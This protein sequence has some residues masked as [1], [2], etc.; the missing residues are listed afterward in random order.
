MMTFARCY[1]VGART[2]AENELACTTQASRRSAPSRVFCRPAIIFPL[3]L[4][5]A[6]LLPGCLLFQQQVVPE[7]TSETDRRAQAE[8]QSR[9]YAQSLARR[10]SEDYRSQAM[11]LLPVLA[12]RELDTVTALVVEWY[13][14]MGEVFPTSATEWAEG[15]PRLHDVRQRAR[16]QQASLLRGDVWE[17]GLPAQVAASTAALMDTLTQYELDREALGN[18]PPERWLELRD[19]YHGWIEVLRILAQAAAAD[20]S[21]AWLGEPLDNGVQATGNGISNSDAGRGV[22]PDEL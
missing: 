4:T 14:I 12:T 3:F 2:L 9:E 13:D 8:A 11:A 15:M 10:L 1:H 5:M 19:A 6:L 22:L 21:R 16:F 18:L 7:G 20:P 17:H